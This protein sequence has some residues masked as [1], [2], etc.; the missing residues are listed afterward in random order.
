MPIEA[1]VDIPL[2]RQGYAVFVKLWDLHAD[3][4]ADE[5]RSIVDTLDQALVAA[6]GNA[7]RG[8][9]S[10]FR[11]PYGGSALFPDIDAGLMSISDILAAL[12][13]AGAAVSIGV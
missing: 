4:P 8:K 5:T 3:S 13:A 11:N 2:W 10:W 6:V 1:S 9:G 12:D 7:G